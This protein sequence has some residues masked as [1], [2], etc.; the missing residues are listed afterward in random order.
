M[1]AQ[2]LFV[3]LVHLFLVVFK[4]KSFYYSPLFIDPTSAFVLALQR[5]FLPCT[6]PYQM[7]VYF[8]PDYLSQPPPIFCH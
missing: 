7:F 6:E 5:P 2:Q 4:V 3:L 1:Q 8:F